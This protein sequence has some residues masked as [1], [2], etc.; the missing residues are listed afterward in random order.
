MDQAFWDTQW[1][2]VQAAPVIYSLGAA[3]FGVFGWW[4]KGQF[5]TSVVHG[6]NAQIAAMKAQIETKDEP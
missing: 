1:K 3:A 4:L 6:L 5:G 2:A